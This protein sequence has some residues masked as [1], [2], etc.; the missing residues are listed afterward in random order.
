MP[1]YKIAAS[2]L[3]ADL[4]C[5]GQEIEA[6]VTAGADFIHFDVMD[7]H[8]V[9]NLSF[10]PMVCAAARRY[11][12]SAA[13]D[14]HLMVKPVD[15]IIADFAEAG[16]GWITFHPEASEHIDRS[17]GL[18]REYG[19][20]CGLALNPA[21]PTN[22]L[23]YI[24]EQLDMVLLMAVNPGFGGQQFM[25]RTLPKI[26]DLRARIDAC[27]KP[28]RLAVDGGVQVDNLRSIAAAG[29]DT[30]VAGSLI[31]RAPDYA[32]VIAQM[33]SILNTVGDH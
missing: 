31:F 30:F 27:G 9:P 6:V 28:I 10:G 22:A 25:P 8:Y 2:I 29:A 13:I 4:A 15:R 33:R 26:R 21:T 32:A 7:N 5:L 24:L 23:D 18:A 20:R 3:A 17:L 1:D 14:V 19:C 16:A 12:G 11:A